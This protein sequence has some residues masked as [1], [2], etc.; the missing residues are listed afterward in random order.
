[1][2]IIMPIAGKG[3]RLWPHTHTVPKP[4]IRVAGKPIIR[5]ILEQ[6]MMLEFTEIIFIIGHL[7]DQIRDY[8]QSHYEFPMKF[9]RQREFK[10]LGHAIYQS[11]NSFTEDESAMVVLGDLIFSADLHSV[12][13]SEHNMLGTWTVDEPQKFG[14]VMEDKERFVTSMIEKPEHPP[15]NKAIAGLYYFKSAFEVFDAV[16]YIIREK[17][18]TRG[19]FQLTDAM[20]NMMY[21]GK[22]FQTFDVLEWYDCGDKETLLKTNEIMLLRHGNAEKIRGSIIIPPVYIGRDA[23]IENSIIGPNVSISEETTIVN[24]IIRNSIIGKESSVENTILD[25]S[26]IGDYAFLSQA[27]LEFNIGSNSEIIFN[28]RST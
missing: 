15:S 25:G 18:M 10:G 23:N 13:K 6:L 7:G 19:E 24:S 28:R 4:L 12:V 20:K 8:L 11:K 1:M 9:I 26:L 17:I 2:K 14:I 27:A 21:R 5:Y 22:K 3:S 16:E